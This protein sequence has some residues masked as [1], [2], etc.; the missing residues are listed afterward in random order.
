VRLAIVHPQ[1]LIRMGVPRLEP[2]RARLDLGFYRSAIKLQNLVAAQKHVSIRRRASHLCSPTSLTRA[3]CSHRRAQR[4]TNG[5]GDFLP[6]ET[7][8]QA[9]RSIRAFFWRLPFLK[10]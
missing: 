4:K 7:S 8:N 3:H 6:E 1:N 10:G 2:R 5:P 9:K